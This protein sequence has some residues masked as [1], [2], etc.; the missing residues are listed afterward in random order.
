[1]IT[2]H[3][4]SDGFPDNSLEF[5]SAMLSEGV[6]AFEIDVQVGPESLYLSHDV[7]M[8]PS[9]AVLLADVFSLMLSHREQRT[10]INV[11][12]KA[13]VDGKAVLRLGRDVGVYDR[14]LLSGSLNLVDYSSE[15]RTH[16]FYNLENAVQDWPLSELQQRQLFKALKSEGLEVVQLYHG[17]VESAHL[18]WLQ[19]SGLQLSVWTPDDFDRIDYLLEIGC[20]NVTTRRAIAYRHR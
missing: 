13:G 11:D 20:Y 10:V 15:E 12:C 1:M 14:V 5:I 2:A 17:L 16:L 18:D 6:Q 3:S 4:G 19:E 9:D 8:D 7:L